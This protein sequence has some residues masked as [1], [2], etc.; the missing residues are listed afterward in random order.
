MAN[1]QSIMEDIGKKAIDFAKRIAGESYV[2][3]V[4]PSKMS[5]M[6]EVGEAINNNAKI[7]AR[8]HADAINKQMPGDIQDFAQT[9]KE[10]GHDINIDGDKAKQIARVMH[11]SDYSEQAFEKLNK[12]LQK[13]GID[14]SNASNL[15]NFIRQQSENILAEQLDVS[16]IPVSQKIPT[17]IQTYLS[18]P[19][20]KVKTQRIATMATSVAGI[21]VGGRYLSGGT[22]TTDKY[23]QKDIAGIPFL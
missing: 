12:E 5:F 23:G 3:N 13:E 10:L 2:N 18:N 14:E 20:K 4:F 8:L 11:G 1:Y 7:N 21:S 16:S 15:T 9:L 19:D 6:N 22:L 17:Y